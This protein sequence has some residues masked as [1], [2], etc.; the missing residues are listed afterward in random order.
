LGTPLLVPVTLIDHDPVLADGL[1]LTFKIAL[2][3]PAVMLLGV[4]VADTPRGK[5]LILRFTV[6]ANPLT[7]VA[8]IV[9]LPVGLADLLSVMLGGFALTEKDPPGVTVAVTEVE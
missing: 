4:I 3:P 9:V 2:A 5:P 7:A 8:L 6:P 1:A